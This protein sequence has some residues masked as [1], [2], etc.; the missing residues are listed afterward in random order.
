MKT[1]Q[2]IP[3]GWPCKLIDCPPG[4][5]SYTGDIGFKS[6]YFNSDPEKIEVFCAESGECFWGGTNDKNARAALVV[7]PV[8]LQWIES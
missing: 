3:H 4:L 8:I 6:E 5:F 7:Q 1:L 2:I